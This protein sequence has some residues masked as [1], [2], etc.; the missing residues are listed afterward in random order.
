[1]SDS[2]FL[3][4]GESKRNMVSFPETETKYENSN[5]LNTDRN[6]FRKPKLNMY[7]YNSNL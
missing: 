6:L 2:D 1:M 7:N 3:I 5:Y 4:M